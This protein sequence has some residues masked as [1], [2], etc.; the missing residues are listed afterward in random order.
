MTVYRA[1]IVIWM[2]SGTL[3]LIMGLIWMQQAASAPGGE[4]GGYTARDFASYFIATWGT[5][6][7]L[8]VWVAWELSFDV[9]QGTLSPKLLRPIDPFWMH[10]IGHWAERVVRL[11]IMFALLVVFA[12]LSGAHYTAEAWPWLAYLLLVPL[13]FTLR[14]LLEYSIGL[15]AF[16]FEAAE[17]FQEL[18]WVLYAALGGL[19]APLSLYPAAVQRFAAFTPFPYMLGLPC[20]L[21]TGKAGLGDALRGFAILLAWTLAFGLLRSWMWRRGVRKYGAVGA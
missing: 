14:F 13:A 17:N 20:D 2:L 10:Y 21:L 6:Q 11:P 1:E 9:R 18:I 8:V 3:S 19:L 16:W 15:L 7:I 12:R 4:I 5:A